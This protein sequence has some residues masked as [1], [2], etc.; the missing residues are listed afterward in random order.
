MFENLKET[1]KF[2]YKDSYE[3][4][5]KIEEELVQVEENSHKYASDSFMDIINKVKDQKEPLNVSSVG[6]NIFYHGIHFL[7]GRG[8]TEE[9]LLEAVRNHYH[10]YDIEVE[11]SDPEPDSDP[12]E[13]DNK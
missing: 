5:D 4:T 3:M 13:K 2:D 8:W 10:M 1:A 6:E 9:S 11:E 7:R 12:T